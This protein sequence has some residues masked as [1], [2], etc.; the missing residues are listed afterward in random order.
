MQTNNKL[1][2]DHLHLRVTTPIFQ[3]IST[4]IYL[5]ECEERKEE[6]SPTNF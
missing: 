3:K 2:M 6:K 4:F 5:K 1:W